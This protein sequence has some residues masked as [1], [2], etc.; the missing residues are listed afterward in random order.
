VYWNGQALSAA[1]PA[2]TAAEAEGEIDELEGEVDEDELKGCC[3]GRD[4]DDDG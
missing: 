3:G 1:A 4:E 2:V